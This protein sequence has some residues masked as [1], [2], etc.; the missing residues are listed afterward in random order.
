[1]FLKISP[2]RNHIYLKF[3]KF[4]GGQHIINDRYG[5]AILI[6]RICGLD[7]EVIVD[8]DFL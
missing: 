6:G 1:M 5:N 8:G 3:Y 2:T 7:E 4:E